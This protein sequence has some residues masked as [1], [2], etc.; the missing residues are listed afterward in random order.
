MPDKIRTVIMA[1]NSGDRQAA[2]AGYTRVLP[3]INHENRQCGF[4]STKAAMVEGG[5]FRSEFCRHQIARRHPETRAQPIEFPRP[6][7]PVVL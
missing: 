5:V 4:R 3:A 2:I 1:N 6:L 7:Y